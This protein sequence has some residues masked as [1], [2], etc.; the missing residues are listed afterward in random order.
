MLSGR[1]GKGGV[2]R[3]LNAWRERTKNH[4]CWKAEATRVQF[5]HSVLFE[6]RW[7][8]TMLSL[9]T[10]FPIWWLVCPTL[11][12]GHRPQWGKA[13]RKPVPLGFN[14]NAYHKP[15][16]SGQEETWVFQGPYLLREASPTQNFACS[17][18][19]V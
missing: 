4:S 1:L 10:H 14:R 7:V 2:Q 9:A 19:T 3:Q 12:E 11:L 5:L 17:I 8:K 13:G 18:H 16:W 6:P 15:S